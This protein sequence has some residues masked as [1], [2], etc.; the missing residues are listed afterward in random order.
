M[1]ARE[2]CLTEKFLQL[3][4]STFGIESFGN[5]G[6]PSRLSLGS[7]SRGFGFGVDLRY[8]DIPAFELEW[9][10]V[11]SSRWCIVSLASRY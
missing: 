8:S 2:L 5:H 3:Y 7:G 6:F 10:A 11:C 9:A 1:Y 4:N